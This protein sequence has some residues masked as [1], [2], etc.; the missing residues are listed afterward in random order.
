MI[1]VKTGNKVESRKM[2]GVYKSKKRAPSCS[3]NLGG[4]V[5]QS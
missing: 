4:C 5:L 1:A 2:L 3:G